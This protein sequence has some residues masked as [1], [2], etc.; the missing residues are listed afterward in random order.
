MT[1]PLIELRSIVK[2]FGEKVVLDGIDLDVARG[3]TVALL[4][5][6][7]TG[8]T[9]LIKTLV[10]LVRVDGGR[11]RVG[12]TDLTRASERDFAPV[13]R[14]IGFVF[15]ASALFDSLTVGEN[16]AYPL[17]IGRPP[18]P[19]ALSA[20]VA[21]CLALVGL[22]GSEPRLPDELSGGMRKRV[23]IARALANRPDVLLYDE[24]TVGLDPANV[25]RIAHL[26]GDLHARFNTTGIVVTHDRELA[27]AVSDRIALLLDGRLA[28]IGRTDDARA[29]PPPVLVA[30]F[31]GEAV[32]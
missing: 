27:F 16:V 12:G 15:Q 23:A 10:G 14:R 3:E 1:E 28:W 24:P 11:V 19:A 17:R 2:R 13:R 32:A 5:P 25:R 31:G 9:V 20:A 7:G 26:I 8:K 4:G 21:E 30:F 29:R 18:D 22:A 6:S